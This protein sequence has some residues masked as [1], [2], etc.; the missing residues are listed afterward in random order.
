MKSSAQYALGA[1][2][3]KV[4]FKYFVL[5]ELTQRIRI[6]ALFEILKECWIRGF[7]YNYRYVKMGKVRVLSIKLMQWF[8]TKMIHNGRFHSSKML[9][10]SN[11]HNGG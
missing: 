5:L 1:L 9:E 10:G 3:A 2:T 6:R 8:P 4:C 7:Y 11:D